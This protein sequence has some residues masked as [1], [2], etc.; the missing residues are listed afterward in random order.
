MYKDSKKEGRESRKER[1]KVCGEGSG[2]RTEQI[3]A[4]FKDFPWWSHG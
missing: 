2:S 4:N 3:I 1:K